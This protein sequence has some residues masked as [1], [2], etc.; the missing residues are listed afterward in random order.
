MFACWHLW[1]T[2][3]NRQHK[4]EKYQ[5][6]NINPTVV[7]SLVIEFI[8]LGPGIH[9][10]KL[11]TSELAYIKWQ[12]P[13]PPFIKLN[14]DGST[15]PNPGHDGIG[16]VFRD[17][18][19]SWFVS[20]ARSISHTTNLHAEILAIKEGLEIALSENYRYLII[21]SD[22]LVAITLL[23]QNDNDKIKFLIDDCRSLIQRAT[24]VKLHHIFREGNKVADKLAAM[25]RILNLTRM[26]IMEQPPANLKDLLSFDLGSGTEQCFVKTGMG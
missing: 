12:P 9:T 26:T 8:T 6:H 16:G 13:N 22:S 15:V 11:G 5:F 19:G 21:E 7:Y 23:Q 3:Y 10:H 25:G 18:T 1:L 2:R 17:H 14:T 24:S 4:S 20:Y